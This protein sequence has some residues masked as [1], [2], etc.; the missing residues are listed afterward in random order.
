MKRRTENGRQKTE[1]RSRK[2]GALSVFR[3]PFSVLHFLVLVLLV[4]SCSAR[5]K[6]VLSMAHVADY[7]WMTA[8]M[9]GELK[10]DNGELPFSGSLRMR[11]DSAIWVSASGMIGM[12][13]CR[14]LVTQDSVIVV[15]R[16][17]KTYLAEP[18]AEM[19]EQ[20]QLPLTLGEGQTLLL[21]DGR[22]DHVELRFGPFIAKIRYSDI[23]WNEPTTFPIR[24]A[25]SYER[26]KP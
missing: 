6:A 4:A 15:N 3:S 16:L 7:E 13:A 19:T 17:D 20:L 18:L 21:G 10:T 9:S 1:D 26:R 2:T 14:A 22:S 12:E 11:R 25:P 24:I 8:K 23:R 5:K